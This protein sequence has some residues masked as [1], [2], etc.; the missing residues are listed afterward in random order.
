MREEKVMRTLIGIV[1]CVILTIGTLLATQGTGGVIVLGW[2][3]LGLVIAYL[4][5]SFTT[6]LGTEVAAMYILGNPVRNMSPG[7]YFTPVGFTTVLRDSSNMFQDELP[8]NPE[9]IFRTDDDKAPIPAGK[10]PPIRIK[11]GQPQDDDDPRLKSDPYNIA[12]VAEVVPVVSWH[13]VDP[14]KFYKALGDVA[15]CRK[16]IAD[17]CVAVFGDEFANVTPAKAALNLKHTSQVLQERLEKEVE[18]GN[19]GIK[20]NDAYVKPFIFSHGFNKAVVGVK[21][22]EEEGKA[23]VITATAEKDAAIQTATGAAKSVELAAAA[24][25]NR[26]IQTGRAKEK[27]GKITRLV[28][29]PDIA[30]QT[31]AVSKLAEL[32]GTLVLGS[33]TPT[34]LGINNKKGGEE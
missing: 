3:L 19:W 34:M 33:E 7:F 16:L 4:I 15:N 27:D 20:I 26:L 5:F 1:L 29:D 6:I 30:A 31:R 13:I 18:D 2:A 14:I 25:R 17:K 10:F 9:N 23:K 22:A 28:P 11:F 32:K 8:S 12:M 21:I 24:E